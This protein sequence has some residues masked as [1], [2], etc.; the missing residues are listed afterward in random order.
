M[1]IIQYDNYTIIKLLRCN[2]YTSLLSIKMFNNDGESTPFS[3][4]LYGAYL[5]MKMSYNMFLMYCVANTLAP[6]KTKECV[7]N[8]AWFGME[9][10]TIIEMNAKNHCY[11]WRDT[12]IE[13]YPVLSKINF[14]NRANKPQNETVIY[15][16]NKGDMVDKNN[17]DVKA[18][19]VKD[20]ESEY[21][22]V[23]DNTLDHTEY[24]FDDK[25]LS[26]KFLACY[27]EDANNRWHLQLLNNKS[28]NGLNYNFYTK[29]NILMTQSFLLYFINNHYN[30]PDGKS[31]KNKLTELIKKGTYKVNI[32][33]NKAN[34]IAWEGTSKAIELHTNGPVVI[35]MNS[36]LQQRK[37]RLSIDVEVCNIDDNLDTLDNSEETVINNEFM[38]EDERI[39]NDNDN[40]NDNDKPLENNIEAE[41]I[42][43]RKLHE[44]ENK[45]LDDSN[46]ET[47]V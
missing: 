44:D 11:K 14:R 12:L 3:F 31:S 42:T 17:P 7:F 23:I 8:I 26:Y 1:I 32:L 40:D 41:G 30:D 34:V 5:G 38:S 15:L 39:D 4:I 18:I 6:R 10:Y 35:E 13:K 29:G 27:V 36:K 46:E 33:D 43:Q 37:P 16:N 2:K 22:S 24:S 9:V 45:Q 25:K 28:N 21:Y 47:E 19:V 20:E